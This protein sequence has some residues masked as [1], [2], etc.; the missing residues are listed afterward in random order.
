M[1][2]TTAGPASE[3]IRTRAYEIGLTSA[4]LT[5]ADVAT[6]D[7]RVYRASERE[8][9][10]ELIDQPTEDVVLETPAAWEFGGTGYNVVHTLFP[11]LIPV[12][13]EPGE[14]I[15]LVYRLNCQQNDQNFT[16]EF[17]HVRQIEP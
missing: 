1:K 14:T 12:D 11:N 2:V 5:P 3:E 10:L 17:T 13:I 7:L 8:P 16:R 4:P 9:I 15:R 6:W